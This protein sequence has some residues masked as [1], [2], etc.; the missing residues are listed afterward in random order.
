MHTLFDWK[1][2]NSAINHVYITAADVKALYPNL[3]RNLIKNALE[4]ALKLSN[5][6]LQSQIIL[7]KLCMHCLNSIVI[8]FRGKFYQQDTG[9]VTGDNN[10]VSM[11]NI[12]LHYVVKGIPEI[13]KYTTLFQRYIDDIMYFS[14]EKEHCIMM[15]QTLTDNFNKYGL[16]LTFR[17]IYTGNAANCE[18]EFLDVLHVSDPSASKGFF[19]K[20]YTKPT[21]INQTFLNGRSHHPKHIFTAIIK[22]EAKRRE[23]LNERKNDFLQSID[24]LET[25]C[26][27]SNFNKILTS[28]A[29]KGIKKNYLDKSNIGNENM[30]KNKDVITWA[31]QFKDLIKF[32]KQEK[33]LAPKSVVSFCK[34]PTLG[35]YLLNYKQISQNNEYIN[36]GT[37]KCK[38]CALCGHHGNF[39]NMVFETNKIRLRNGKEIK[40]K[41]NLNCKNFGIYG[42]QC[43]I[44]NEYYVG[45]TK[46]SFSKRWT[47]H[48]FHWN[49][50]MDKRE[51][52]VA[53]FKGKKINKMELKDD[54]ALFAHFAQQHPECLKENLFL[55]D[56]YQVVFL[57]KPH[58][59]QLDTEEN[60][61]I[62]KLNAKIN[63]M[64]TFLPKYK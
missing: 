62:S 18:I 12:G 33:E 14:E 15:K 37:R 16:K 20:D 25:K 29:I 40:L 45:Q 22:G 57:W 21:A 38:H 3:S 27:R 41:H 28:N 48:R 52:M 51:D 50:M 46:S 24:Q 8:Q 63:I 32:S 43:I 47:S 30:D 60:N 58:V 42:A 9:I 4:D 59:E 36:G 39:K 7:I 54:Q 10:S 1:N 44:C 23:R 56:A 11:A 31:T 61:W 6:P 2:K 53:E 49:K 55:Y 5:F 26:M 19:T 64:R 35:N 13:N 17:E 34:P